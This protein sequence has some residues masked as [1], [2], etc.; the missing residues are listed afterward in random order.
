MS[1][2]KFDVHQQTTDHTFD[3]ERGQGSV[4]GMRGRYNKRGG[5]DECR[6]YPPAPLSSFVVD[7]G[8]S[9]HMV[10]DW[11]L[12]TN[13]RDT[14]PVLI[15]VGNGELLTSRQRGRLTIGLSV[16]QTPD[17]YRWSFHH[18]QAVLS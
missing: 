2:W 9:D 6:L 1:D 13:V 10:V 3:D 4:R 8:A 18:G 12:L 15:L 7:S 11:D 14:H 16:Q 5:S 17:T